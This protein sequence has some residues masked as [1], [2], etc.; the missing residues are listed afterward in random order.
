MET[1]EEAT[2]PNRSVRRRRSWVA[3]AAVATGLALGAAGLAGAATG[4]SGTAATSTGSS[5]A[6]ADAALAPPAGPK[7]TPPDPSTMKQ[8]PGETLLAGDTAAKVEAAAFKAVPGA[9]LIRV[10]TDSSGGTYEAH[11][12][13]ADGSFVT[14]AFDADVNVTSTNDGF[15]RGPQGQ[16]PPAGAPAAAPRD[17]SRPN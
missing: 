4:S 3:T 5:T 15:G 6:V 8:G 12:K 17:A 11:L 10:E 13:K 16:A 7:G 1:N 14:V 2:T 9:T